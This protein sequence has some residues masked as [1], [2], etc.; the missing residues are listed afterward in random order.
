V[1]TLA[2]LT[3]FQVITT[4]LSEVD[5]AQ[6]VEGQTASIVFDAIPESTFLGTVEKI[7]DKSSGVSSVYYQVTLSLNE[8]P[9]E[10]RWGMTAFVI[11]PVD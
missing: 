4:D 11:F 2:D 1:L 5:V 7:A 3:A 10:I 9:P 6:L 8:I